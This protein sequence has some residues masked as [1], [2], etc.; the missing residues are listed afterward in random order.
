MKTNKEVTLFY[1]DHTI[2]RISEEKLNKEDLLLAEYIMTRNTDD[3]NF[4]LTPTSYLMLFDNAVIEYKINCAIP[5]D[6]EICDIT[7]LITTKT[8]SIT[9]VLSLINSIDR[10]NCVNRIFEEENVGIPLALGVGYFNLILEKKG[11][12]TFQKEYK[13]SKLGLTTAY[14]SYFITKKFKK[15]YSVDLINE[16][17]LNNQFLFLYEDM[18]WEFGNYMKKPGLVG[19]PLALSNT[20]TFCTTTEAVKLSRFRSI[21]CSYLV[22]DTTG[23]EE[24]SLKL[25]DMVKEG[26]YDDLVE[27]DPY[28]DYMMETFVT[29]SLTASTRYFHVEL[30]SHLEFLL[31]AYKFAFPSEEKE[32]D[33]KDRDSFTLLSA[34]AIELHSL[35]E[36][37]EFMFTENTVLPISDILKVI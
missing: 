4:I 14:Y 2:K 32:D 36:T 35:K 33:H 8:D 11:K 7:P 23:A 28:F 24:Q 25:E 31:L 18:T 17:S 3:R 9:D 27:L 15:I 22:I 19:I 16:I 37:K 29:V 10:L 12:V 6:D 20:I 5:G 21:N 1:Q 26:K 13:D 30:L 34:I